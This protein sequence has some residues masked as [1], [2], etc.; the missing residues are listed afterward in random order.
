MVDTKI[1]GAF[2]GYKGSV[3]IEGSFGL[4]NIQGGKKVVGGGSL[5][6]LNGL[7]GD[8]TLSTTMG[9][10]V[11]ELIKNSKADETHAIA[12]SNGNRSVAERAIYE[13]GLLVAREFAVYTATGTVV[14]GRLEDGKINQIQV[15]YGQRYGTVVLEALI[16]MLASSDAEFKS[17]IEEIGTLSS[18][19]NFIKVLAAL[20]DNAYYR[21]K[22]GKFKFQAKLKNNTWNVPLIKKA[23]IEAGLYSMES[24]EEVIGAINDS[25]LAQFSSGCQ[26]IGGK[27]IKPSDLAGKFTDDKGKNLSEKEEQK[28]PKIPDYVVVPD[29]IPTICELISKTRNTNRPIQN[30]LFTGPA[31]TG[32]SLNS[33]LIAAA[34]N[35]PRVLMVGSS[36]MEII[37]L[38][39]TYVPRVT[40]QGIETG[41]DDLPTV[42]DISFDLEESYKQ[43]TGEDTMPKGV[44][45]EEVV[46]LLFEKQ[47]GIIDN[48]GGSQGTDFIF[49]P[50]PLVQAVKN[51][52]LVE[53]QEFNMILNAG[54][55]TG[56]N[57]ILEG[58]QI[59]L[60][61][62][63]VVHRHPESI[64]VF[65]M[66][67]NYEGCR[68]LN[69]SVLDRFPIKVEIPLPTD[70]E[71]IK[72]VKNV[73]DC[74]DTAFVANQLEC[75]KAIVE[76]LASQGY[77][78]VLGMRALYDWTLTAITLK[79]MMLAA[80]F[81]ILESAMPS[82]LEDAERQELKDF[83][84]NNILAPNVIEVS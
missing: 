50:S 63:E 33:E 7:K 61:T 73:C 60:P 12:Y 39:G 25:Y 26:P 27:T 31:G 69:Q 5:H 82:L 54:V 80:E 16:P 34:F 28:V 47:Q 17:L 84:R 79:D 37:D 8:G 30:I 38:T 83:I 6:S 29:N 78:G 68:P 76:H 20:S 11:K 43:L 53:C 48:F 77:N 14:A 51:G 52:W 21:L 9:K 81:T 2:M 62:G 49:V 72:R 74:K 67:T 18:G 32:K 58:K 19:D 22:D 36:S 23:S 3:D 10:A 64:I 71:I 24:G 59:N 41:I 44:T 1:L 66:N 56:L 55:L 70:K 15:G 13:N 40:P 65:T 57:S 45:F 4:L 75:Y 42:E 46:N 35:K